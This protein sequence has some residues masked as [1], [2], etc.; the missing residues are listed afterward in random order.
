MTPIFEKLSAALSLDQIQA[1][2][3]QKEPDEGPLVQIGTDG[4]FSL[5]TFDGDLDPPQKAATLRKL[6]GATP[7]SVSGQVLRCDG[8]IFVSSVLTRVAAYRASPPNVGAPVG[9]QATAR[10]AFDFFVATQWSKAQAAGLIANIEAESSFRI[11]VPGDGG[12]AYGLCQWHLDRQANFST[13]FGKNIR[14]ST[15]EEQ[16]QFINFELRQGKEQAAGILLKDSLAPQ[17]AGEIVSASYLRPK[18]PKGEKKAERGA[19][20]VVWFNLFP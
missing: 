8:N 20:A 5:L 12:A 6:D 16:L 1:I 14:G 2:L 13:E 7:P 11:D 15:F 19:R 10:R 3:D 9:D 17:Q 18:D 4:Q